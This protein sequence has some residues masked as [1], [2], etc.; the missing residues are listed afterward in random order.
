MKREVYRRATSRTRRKIQSA[1][2]ELLA[3]H[4]AINNIS[5]T[6]LAER[7]EITRG[8]FYN[9]YNNIHEVGAELQK[10]L[11]KR[12]FSEYDSLDN[13]DSIERYIDDVFNYF[14]RQEGIYRELL[15][16]DASTDF[17]YQLENS[18]SKRV[19]AVLHN[20]GVTDKSA[21]LE[22]LFTINGAIAIVRKHYRGEIE[23]SLDEIRDYLKSKIGWMFKKY[24]INEN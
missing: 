6:D 1:F 4:G 3:E 14:D 12:L 11:E 23:L 8:T 5:V 16:S 17:L 19:L 2:A 20:N 21:E 22:L 15:S 24:V 7:A 9:Y 10:E 13:L 18:M